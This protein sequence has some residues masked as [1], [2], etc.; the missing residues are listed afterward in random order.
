M[1]DQPEEQHASAT[2]TVADAM[3][4]VQ[5]NKPDDAVLL[6][7]TAVSMAGA[8]GRTHA[9]LA[10]LLL[11]RF[12]ALLTVVKGNATIAAPDELIH[13]GVDKRVLT[14]LDLA[15]EH[16]REAIK[17]GHD[18]AEL[19]NNYGIALTY[20]HEDEEAIAELNRAVELDPESPYTEWILARLLVKAKRYDEAFAHCQH[21]ITAMPNHPGLLNTIGKIYFA[22]GRYHDA[23]EV[24][25]KA[26]AL[27]PNNV[28][29]Q[30]D[31]GVTY[32][33]VGRYDLAIPLLQS[34]H[35]NRPTDIL[36][37]ENLATT[38][39][40][41]QRP[42]DAI[43]LYDNA[44]KLDPT[45]VEAGFRL[46][47]LQLGTGQ[48]EA[49]WEKYGLRW[50]VINSRPLERIN[51]HNPGLLAGAIHVYFDQGIGDEIFF[52]RFV[53]LLKERGQRIHYCAG[54]Q[55]EPIARRLKYFDE[56]IPATQ[57]RTLI[58]RN[59]IAVGDLPKVLGIRTRSQIPPPLRLFPLAERVE[60]MRK[61]LTAAGPPPYIGV[62]WRAGTR[63]ENTDLSL[64]G[65]FLFKEAPI[66]MVGAALR[67][68]PG[69][70]VVLQRLPDEGEYAI[71]ENAMQRPAS[72]FS[73]INDD[74]EDMLALLSLLD[75]YVTVSNTN[76]H[77]LAGLEKTARI[78]IPLPPEW[79]W[80]M[81][82]NESPWFPGFRLYR[83]DTRLD[84]DRA[85]GDLRRDLRQ[86][87]GIR[88]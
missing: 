64:A 57:I 52:L 28:A 13:S 16:Y 48:F 70:I 79:R 36:A 71:L 15:I 69:T 74:L 61:K 68:L 38:Y 6:L 63:R 62:T 72:D 20:R 5:A 58:G 4:L 41:A 47:T 51:L 30:Q 84:W 37:L 55:F 18:N 87:L 88:R 39:S 2:S 24:N 46:C 45:N 80:M 53:P 3:A 1:H 9:M 23:I 10:D 21:A 60:A 73:T 29:I 31:L 14:E 83:R 26:T 86:A 25:K 65:G 49:G 8:D 54:P 33:V 67:N 44:F 27:S 32:N 78:L 22:Q 75:E 7:Q 59:P 50:A 19:H 56:V 77:L 11:S 42:Q 35:R 34:V 12:R 40:L 43:A 85:F 81:S 76:V 66:E 17:L 82:G